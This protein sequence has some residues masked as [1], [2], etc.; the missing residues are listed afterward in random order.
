MAFGSCS[1][2]FTMLC[3]ML[4]TLLVDDAQ[5][6]LDAARR[7][8]MMRS[9][10]TTVLFDAVRSCWVSAASARNAAAAQRHTR[11]SLC[12]MRPIRSSCQTPSHEN[13]IDLSKKKRKAVSTQNVTRLRF[14]SF[15]AKGSIHRSRF[16]YEQREPTGSACPT[17]LCI[18]YAKP[19]TDVCM[20]LPGTSGSRRALSVRCPKC[21][22]FLVSGVHAMPLLVLNVVYAATNLLCR[23][24]YR[25][26]R[27]LLATNPAVS[28]T[29]CRV[30]CYELAMA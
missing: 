6:L 7:C 12:I 27:V 26:Q 17:V 20:L 21:E 4:T 23:C 18:C 14:F 10:Q 2:L 22:V 1:M 19:G 29:V 3:L 16:S 15:S 24:W 5:C 11:S 30:C 28:G 25:Q 8:P 13:K 9:M